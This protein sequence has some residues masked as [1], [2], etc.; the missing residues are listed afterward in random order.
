MLETIETRDIEPRPRY[1]RIP[2]SKGPDGER[3]FGKPVPVFSEELHRE[4]IQSPVTRESKFNS[5]P[6]EVILLEV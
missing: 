4:Q 1:Y 2:Q 6:S 5:Q 3:Q